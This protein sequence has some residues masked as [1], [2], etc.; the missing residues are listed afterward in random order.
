MLRGPL[1]VASNRSLSILLPRPGTRAL[2]VSVIRPIS[3][4]IYMYYD[5]TSDIRTV[6][7][8]NEISR[9]RLAWELFWPR[10]RCLPQKEAAGSKTSQVTDTGPLSVRDEAVRETTTPQKL[11]LIIKKRRLEWF[12]NI[13]RMDNGRLPKQIMYQEI[14]RRP[15]RPRKNHIDTIRRDVDT[16][17]TKNQVCESSDHG[18]L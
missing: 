18:A 13:L 9:F 4:R 16:G 8:A 14:N 12:G 15:G 5:G 10:L 6:Q 11:E 17:C 1:A 7:T 2:I 3:A